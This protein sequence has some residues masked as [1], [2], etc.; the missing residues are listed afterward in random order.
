MQKKGNT[1]RYS[2]AEIDAVLKKGGSK[3]DWAKVDGTTQ[4]DLERSIDADP[5]DLRGG[6][7]VD[8][9]QTAFDGTIIVDLSDTKPLLCRIARATFERRFARS[10]TV[11]DC[12]LITARYPAVIRAILDGKRSQPDAVT[13]AGT[14][15][16]VDLSLD[17]IQSWEASTG[18]RL[19]DD[20]LAVQ[21]RAGF[22]DKSGRIVRA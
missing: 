3:T 17:D 2:A 9:T 5:D 16:V 19:S 13:D 6:L 8:F 7:A 11:A 14:H 18:K 12:N 22:A 4:A 21:K 15:F 10:L 1:V 20:V